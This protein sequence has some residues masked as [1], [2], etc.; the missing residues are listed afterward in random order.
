[1]VG[2]KD[3]KV[4][5]LANWPEP[6]AGS[7]TLTFRIGRPERV[8]VSIYNIRGERVITLCD[9]H[10]KADTY[11]L[12]WDGTTDLGRPAPSGVYFC[13]LAAGDACLTDKM[14]LMR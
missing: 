1:L 2:S 5:S 8:T 13:R 4:F 3:A 6:F 10:M 7:T 11:K 12:I 9:G 14:V